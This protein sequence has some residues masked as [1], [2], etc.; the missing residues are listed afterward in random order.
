MWIL[1][2]PLYDEDSSFILGL[3]QSILPL[4]LLLAEPGESRLWNGINHHL[5]KL[6][7]RFEVADVDYWFGVVENCPCL[8][9]SPAV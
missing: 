7:I 3:R 6:L 4:P 8:G 1:Q 2:V 5:P 9:C